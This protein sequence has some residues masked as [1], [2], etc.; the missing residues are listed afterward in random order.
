MHNPWGDYLK[1]R[2]QLIHHWYKEGIPGYSARPTPEL[3]ARELN[4]VEPGQVR[5]LLATP[6]EPESILL[7]DVVKRHVLNVY[8]DNGSNLSATVKALGVSRSNLYRWFKKWG[9]K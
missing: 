9:V 6:I 2:L 5:L 3:I 7:K 8:R 1:V 4:H